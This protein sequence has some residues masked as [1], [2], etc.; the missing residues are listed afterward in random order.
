M[1]LVRRAL[2]VLGIAAIAACTHA[3][4]DVTSD[5]HLLTF[6]ASL[7][8][9]QE[10]PPVSTLG[11][12]Q[13]DAVFDSRT[14]QLRWKLSYS[15]L[16]G[17]ATAGHFHGP[18]QPGANAGVVLPLGARMSSPLE[19]SAQLSEAQAAD[20]LAG[21]WYVNLHTAAFPVGEIRGQLTQR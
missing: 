4:P 10:V 8:G 3:Q 20:L 1:T 15:S 13:L 12:G 9:D 11:Q 16:T 21:R 5:A 6:S 14:R 18:A 7:R 2:V 17:P 19:G